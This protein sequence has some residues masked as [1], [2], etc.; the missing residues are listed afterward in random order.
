MLTGAILEGCMAI[1][2]AE[3]SNQTRED[4][5]KVLT[6]LLQGLRTQI[7]TNNDQTLQQSNNS[8]R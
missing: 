7:P 8:P 1:T 6:A 3:D 4:V 5:G 2:D